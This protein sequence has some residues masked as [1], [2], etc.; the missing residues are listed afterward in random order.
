MSLFG[1]KPVAIINFKTYEEST[2][3]K[4]VELALI[5]EKVAKETGKEIWIAVHPTDIRNIVSA[6]SIPVLCQHADPVLYGAYTGWLPP[7][8]LK[9]MG[10]KGT[11]LNHS[12]HQ[13]PLDVLETTVSLCRK[14]G[15]SIVICAD[16]PSKAGEVAKFK[17][18]YVAIEPPEL[19]GGEI[20]VSTAQPEIITESVHNVRA[21]AQIPVLC[22]AGIK[23]AQDVKKAIE[24]GAKGILVASGV[25][26]SN[27]PEKAIRDL[28]SGF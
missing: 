19:I 5:C 24:L 6:V 16:T 13:M 18:D 23:N 17:P 27:D 22:G 25:T 11:L 20:S 3:V 10:A 14:A 8:M 9:E 1:D 21:E 26:K 2:G 28:V 4:G 7:M 12:E 15:L